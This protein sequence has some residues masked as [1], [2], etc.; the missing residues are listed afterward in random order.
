MPIIGA[1][2]IPQALNHSN[3]SLSFL[4]IFLVKQSTGFLL[5]LPGTHRKRMMSPFSSCLQIMID[6]AFSPLPTV[7]LPLRNKSHSVFSCRPR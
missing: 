5:F 1:A 4:F 6:F 3:E 2:F 7:S